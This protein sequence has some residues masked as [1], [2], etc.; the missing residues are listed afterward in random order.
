MKKKIIKYKLE[1]MGILVGSV[2]G[3]MYWFFI[4]C[5]SGTCAI[6]SHPINS[7][8]YGAFMGAV[9]LGILRKETK[10][11]EQQKSIK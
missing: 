10:K 2:G 5:S 7:S 4:G 3:W 9:L 1:L 8:L 6:T 11:E